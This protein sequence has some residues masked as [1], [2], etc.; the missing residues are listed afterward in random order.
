MQG[1]S[2]RVGGGGGGRLEIE[3]GSDGTRCGGWGKGLDC[4]GDRHT[5]DLC[6][7]S[8]KSPFPFRM[9]ARCGEIWKELQK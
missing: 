2:L 4:E 1:R 7:I 9:I 3:K 5:N 8:W 6:L